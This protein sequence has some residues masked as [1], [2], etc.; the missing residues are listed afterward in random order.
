MHHLS[1]ALVI[2]SLVVNVLFAE[3]ELDQGYVL[4][5]AR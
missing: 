4:P 3:P 2:L 1:A 5:Q